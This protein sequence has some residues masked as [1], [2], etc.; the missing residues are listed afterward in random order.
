MLADENLSP[1]YLAF[2]ALDECA[3]A[4]EDTPSV[5]GLISLIAG[6]LSCTGQ[7]SKKIKWLVSSRP[8]VDVYNKLQPARE[9]AV[10]ELDVMAHKEPVDAYVN[11]QLSQLRIKHKYTQDKL[12]A[13]SAELRRHE[14]LTFLWIAL[15]LKDLLTGDVT[16]RKA[17]QHVQGT[18]P[19]LSEIYDRMME[20]I[21]KI[22][23]EEG[24]ELCMRLLEAVCFASRPVSYAEAQAV[25]GLPSD[26]TDEIL[27]ICGS[28]LTSHDGTV[29]ILHNS[30]RQHLTAYFESNRK[31]GA[32]Q[33]HESIAKRSIAAMSDGLRYNMYGL[34]AGTESTDIIARED[35]GPLASLCYSCE[36]WVDHLCGPDGPREGQLLDDGAAFV[37]LEKHFLHWLEALSLIHKLPTALSSI[38]KLISNLKKV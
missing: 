26:A 7:N 32:G 24:K 28:F 12:D 20:R 9:E 30:T 38:R 1:V 19:K 27:Q 4:T 15:V 17:V 10:I 14:N 16:Q 3:E 25:A 8:E 18:P 35:Y 2:D 36:F 11:H 13:I 29:H 33:I 6:T 21:E 23:D 22:M 31:G 5:Q 37:F 34:N